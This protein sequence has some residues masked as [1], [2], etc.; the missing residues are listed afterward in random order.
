MGFSARLLARRPVLRQSARQTSQHFLQQVI[1][2]GPNLAPP[3]AHCKRHA[4]RIDQRQLQT[5]RD[6]DARRRLCGAAF[7]RSSVVPARFA[8]NALDQRPVHR[9]PCVALT[10][11][12]AKAYG[13]R[14]IVDRPR[15]PL[16]YPGR[17]YRQHLPRGT[18]RLFARRAQQ[19][20]ELGRRFKP[21]QRSKAIAF[22][23]SGHLDI[24]RGQREPPVHSLLKPLQAQIP[25]RCRPLARRAAIT[26]RPPR[27]LIR[28][29]NP[30]VRARLTLE[31]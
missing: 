12:D 16:R 11:G 17:A 27:D 30:C 26:A 7:E 28:T 2:V 6:V 1:G 20:R 9:A 8:H 10:H 31:G 13:S 29:R 3:H 22:V 25:S 23:T 21:A 5:Q 4:L 15:R 14:R 24:H 18:D 19:R